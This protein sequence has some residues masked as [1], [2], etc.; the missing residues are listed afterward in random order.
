M[1]PHGRRR[2]G[3]LAG[4]A[5]L[6][7]AMAAPARGAPESV[8]VLGSHP[9]RLGDELVRELEAAG[10]A[11]VRTNP[12]ERG[13]WRSGPAS[14]GGDQ[15]H[16]IAV[17][18]DPD[19]VVVLERDRD[20]IHIRLE[21]ELDPRDRLA[22]R[23]ACLAVVEHLRVLAA[24][25]ERVSAP[26]P[27]F[28]GGAV[29]GPPGAL[30][31]VTTVAT[32]AGGPPTALAAPSSEARFRGWALGAAT[33]LNL[34]SALGEPT[35]H[36]QLLARFPLGPRWAA[37]A[38]GL[39]PLLGAQLQ[40]DGVYCRIWTFGAAVGVERAFAA[41]PARLRPF[42]AAVVGTR[43]VLADVAW[44]ETRQAHVSFTPGATIGLQAG[45]RYQIVP[46]AQLLFELEVADAWALARGGPSRHAREVTSARSAHASLGVLFE[47]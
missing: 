42:V 17:A 19:R 37:R 45:A 26:A 1:P 33:T 9:S 2:Y 4:V 43:F 10:F 14:A 24:G 39:W 22:R 5:A 15:A 3:P 13:S 40:A 20:A 18:A 41:A 12:A 29:D 25:T 21:V 23:R 34:D 7:I 16:A 44:I 36:V 30:G 38:R 31:S 46:R 35:G 27:V 6:V 28:A 47:Y 11:L 32:E 8:I